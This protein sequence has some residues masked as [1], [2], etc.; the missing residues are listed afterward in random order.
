MFCTVLWETFMF[1]YNRKVCMQ[2]GKRWKQVKAKNWRGA[3]AFTFHW[4]SLGF[5]FTYCS[6]NFNQNPWKKV[7]PLK[8]W[9]AQGV[10]FGCQWSYLHFQKQEFQLAELLNW[11]PQSKH[12]TK[13]GS[14]FS[15]YFQEVYLLH[16]TEIFVTREIS[17]P[18]RE[19]EGLRFYV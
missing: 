15:F 8:Y 9:R 11:N 6:M 4:T 12:F 17:G 2:K 18:R 1:C 13:D 3:Y 19:I 10:Y 7:T 5:E 16:Q 14:M